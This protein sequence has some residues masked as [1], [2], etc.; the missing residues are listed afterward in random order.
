MKYVFHSK[1]TGFT[2]AFK[3][4]SDL[5][6]YLPPESTMCVKGTVHNYFWRTKKD[7][8]ENNVCKI[9]RLLNE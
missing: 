4:L 2:K 7:V 3:T 1:I 6:Y 8:Y 9:V 5:F